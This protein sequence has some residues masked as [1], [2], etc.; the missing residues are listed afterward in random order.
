[1]RR[2]VMCPK[3]FARTVFSEISRPRAWRFVMKHCLV[4]LYQV[5]L[6][7]DPRVQNGP[8]AGGS[9]VIKLDMPKNLLQNC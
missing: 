4:D 8:A 2:L 9:W 1:M 6:V 5:C 7:R 3:Q